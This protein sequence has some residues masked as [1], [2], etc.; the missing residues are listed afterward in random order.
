MQSKT[1]SNLLFIIGILILIL[2]GYFFNLAK[3]VEGVGGIIPVFISIALLPLSLLL[4]IIGFF[5]GKESID[6]NNS[7]PEVYNANKTKRMIRSYIIGSI[8]TLMGFIPRI[9]GINGDTLHAA[10][11]IFSFVQLFG[12]LILLVSIYQTI[13]ILFS[14]LFNKN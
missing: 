2:C 14:K 1:K 9:V 4:I 11:I 3:E 13:S 5:K 12:I 8:L 6:H 7:S 10:D